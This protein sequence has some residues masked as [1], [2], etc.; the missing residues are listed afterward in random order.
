MVNLER[1][2]EEVVAKGCIPNS[3]LAVRCSFSPRFLCRFVQHV[4]TCRYSAHAIKELAVEEAAGQADVS[5][6]NLA[7]R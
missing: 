6:Q 7:K 2:E 4:S 5:G 1:S 3:H